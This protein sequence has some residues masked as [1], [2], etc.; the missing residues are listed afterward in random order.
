MAKK[1]F[2]IFVLLII[3][4][5]AVAQQEW[6]LQQCI[7]YALK[8]NF[9]VKQSNLQVQQANSNL[10]QSKFSV[11][12][13]VNGTISN[14]YNIGKRIDPFTNKFA[15]SQVRSDNYSI[16]AN[17][18]LFNGLQQY[19]TIKQNQQYIEASKLD[20]DANTQNLILNIAS[21]YLNI[22]FAQ[23]QLV[24]AKNQVDIT[25]QQEIHTQKLIDAGAAAKNILL[26]IQSQLANEELQ[27]VNAQN[28]LDLAY[29]SLALLLDI[30]NNENISIQKPNLPEPN[31]N[32]EIANV[33][34]AIGFATN[35]Q[36]ALKAAEVRARAAYTSI[37]IAK[38]AVL[39][40]LSLGG[41]YGT[42]FS[43]LATTPFGQTTF[44]QTIGQTLLTNED[45]I[46]TQVVPEGYKTTPYGKQLNSN[47]NKSFGVQLSIPIFNGFQ[48]KNQIQRAKINY[49]NAKLNTSI[50]KR[51]IVRI[52]KQSYAD[53]VA[54]IKKYKATQKSVNALQA[55]FKNTE[56]RFNLGVVNTF[57]FNDSKNKI[58]K[59]NIDLIQAKYDY[60]FKLKVLEFYQGKPITL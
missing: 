53:A 29:L 59:A 58:A 20:A 5:V 23:E 44:T 43:G 31:F 16:N 46:Y 24:A 33:D 12:P 32:D 38:G 28:T 51:D 52:V 36:P 1:Y 30:Q 13:S 48:V 14:Y 55:S 40:S 57:E 39:P 35:N 54:A 27:I 8:N 7:D 15:N 47:V 18:T 49:E 4:N 3:A 50:A 26:D 56:T 25:Q 21:A 11:L 41:S 42:G 22:L 10:E 9:N 6:S 60:Y 2:S 45:V 19:N 17:L 34:V 37:E